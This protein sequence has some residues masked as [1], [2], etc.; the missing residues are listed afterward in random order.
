MTFV[1]RV[2]RAEVC[3]GCRIISPPLKPCTLIQVFILENRTDTVMRERMAAISPDLIGTIKLGLP[4]IKMPIP[5]PCTANPCVI[6]VSSGFIGTCYG[7]Q[8]RRGCRRTR[9]PMEFPLL[10]II[11]ISEELPGEIIN[12]PYDSGFCPV[13]LP[14][15]PPFAD[16]CSDDMLGRT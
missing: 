14:V 13:I 3:T 6:Q 2:I 11:I 4:I 8:V 7:D 9:S 5:Y 15:G 12:G 10:F 1:W 16:M